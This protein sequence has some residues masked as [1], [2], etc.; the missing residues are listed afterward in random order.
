MSKQAKDRFR[1]SPARDFADRANSPDFPA[2]SAPR[3]P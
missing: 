3:L 2:P 1:G